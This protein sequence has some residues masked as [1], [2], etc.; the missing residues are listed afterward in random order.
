MYTRVTTALN[1]TFVFVLRFGFTRPSSCAFSLAQT[2][3]IPS[4]NAPCECV[5]IFSFI[6]FKI[7]K[8]S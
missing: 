6:I 8:S 7:F 5:V 1:A 3:A 2:V 4:Q